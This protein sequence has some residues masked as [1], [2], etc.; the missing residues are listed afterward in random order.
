MMREKEKMSKD[1]VQLLGI[2]LSVP[3]K[4]QALLLETTKFNS[5]ACCKLPGKM[6]IMTENVQA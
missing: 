6:Q 5:Q 3:P 1:F 2:A 4:S